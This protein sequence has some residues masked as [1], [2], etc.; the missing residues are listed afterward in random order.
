MFADRANQTFIKD[1]PLIIDDIILDE[2]VAST[3]GTRLAVTLRKIQKAKRLRVNYEF[4]KSLGVSK[5]VAQIIMDIF[6]VDKHGFADRDMIIDR[7]IEIYESRKNMQLTLG[8][9][10][11]VLA[12]LER[13]MLTALYIVL[14][15]I[16]LAIFEQNVLEMWLT[17][18]SFI[19]AFAFMFGNSIRECFE[20]V[21]FIFITH[22]YDVGDNIL[23]NGNRFVIK[24]INILQTE[25]ENWNGEVTYYHNQTM[26]RST[27][28]NM[29]RSKTRTESFDWIVDVETN[30]KVFDGLNSS[31][32][33][34]TALNSADVDECFLKVVPC[35]DY[36][37]KI[38]ITVF[39]DLK[40]N[41]L[42]VLRS[43]AVRNAVNNHVRK[44]FV[45]NNVKLHSLPLT[46]DGHL[47]TT[48]ANTT[49]TGNISAP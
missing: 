11:S 49:S 18:S 42:P 48:T 5:E 14:I 44:Y 39:L 43:L 45:A 37:G 6:D 12:T 47:N 19:L 17:L 26:M 21:I 41:G 22:P 1:E 38:R 33:N 9:S 34:F 15:F 4:L 36:T 2:S 8:G 35:G 27:V 24:N 7:V 16:V 3:C 31:L 40:F 30:D 20:G 10:R 46:I 25:A 32:H 13:M 23:I 28:I 29:S